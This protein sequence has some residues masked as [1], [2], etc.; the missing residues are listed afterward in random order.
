MTVTHFPGGRLCGLN[1]AMDGA[2]EAAVCG[3]WLVIGS[4]AE[5]TAGSDRTRRLRR[6]A[7]RQ[8]PFRQQGR[9]SLA[10]AAR[11]GK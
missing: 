2:L 6:R 1:V 7:D 9:Q 3:P 8:P 11:T 5:A 4:T 10:R